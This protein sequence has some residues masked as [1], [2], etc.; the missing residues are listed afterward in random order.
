LATHEANPNLTLYDA[1][2]M[3]ELLDQPLAQPRLSALLMSGFSVV[4]LLLSA[5]G[6]YG[7][8]SSAV[9]RQTRDI[10]VRMALGATPRHVRRL[11]LGEAIGVVGIGAL[12]GIG[13]AVISARLLASQLFGVSPLDPPSLVVAASLLLVIGVCAAYFPAR[14]AVRIDPMQAL[15]VE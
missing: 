1:T 9:R 3:D 11:V 7:V 5:V 15:R 10:G 4:A 2:T 13:G 6:L 14:R 12:I 8:M